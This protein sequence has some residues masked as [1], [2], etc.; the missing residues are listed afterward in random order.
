MVIFGIRVFE[1]TVSYCSAYSPCVAVS[2]LGLRKYD[3][4]NWYANMPKG[5]KIFVYLI[6]T[7]FL[8][9]FG[10]G[11][12]PLAVLIYLELGQRGREE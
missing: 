9:F 2:F 1:D 12:L 10:A 4:K 6:S 5:Q 8:V 7:A 3:M 11:L